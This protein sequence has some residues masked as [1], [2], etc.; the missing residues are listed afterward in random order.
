MYQRGTDNTNAE[1]IR[2]LWGTRPGHF[3]CIDRLL[4]QRGA[5][6]T[7]L[8]GPVNPHPATVIELALPDPSIGK[9]GILVF[10]RRCLRPIRLQPG[11]QCLPVLLIFRRKSQVHATLLHPP[12]CSGTRRLISLSIEVERGKP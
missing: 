6:P 11:P 1:T 10:W 9:L 12:R 3:L 8:L 5:L 2:R 4:D 7:V